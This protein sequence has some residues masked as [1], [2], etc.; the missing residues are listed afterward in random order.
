MNAEALEL[1]LE[2]TPGLV[3]ADASDHPAGR[4]QG[5][6]VGRYVAGT[7]HGR[8]AL[9][10]PHHRHRSLRRYAIHGT[11]DVPVEHEVADHQDSHASRRG[12][13]LVQALGV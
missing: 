5:R 7:T 11:G 3:V 10:Y 9:G 6:D 8:D 2:Q 13:E 1:V 12:E 4:P